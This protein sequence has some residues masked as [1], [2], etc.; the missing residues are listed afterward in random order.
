[1]F[2]FC[3]CF[4]ISMEMVCEIWFVR[5]WR[6]LWKASDLLHLRADCIFFTILILYYYFLQP[7]HV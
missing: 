3:F 5:Y 1:M 7:L 4:L 6:R 2:V